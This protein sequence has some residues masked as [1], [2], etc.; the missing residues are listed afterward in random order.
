[1]EYSAWNQLSFAWPEECQSIVIKHG[2]FPQKSILDLKCRDSNAK[3]SETGAHS[4]RPCRGGGFRRREY[5][6]FKNWFFAYIR[7]DLTDF[8]ACGMIIA[9]PRD[10]TG[11]CR[12]YGRLVHSPREGGDKAWIR[13]I[14][15]G[16]WSTSSYGSSC[17]PLQYTLL[18]KRV[19]RPAATGRSM[20]FEIWQPKE[21]TA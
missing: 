2:Y 14:S 3:K 12:K 15:G 18:Q 5:L 4:V 8:V 11:R 10:G 17:L 21:L 6:H 20:I 7:W 13:S 19:D 16:S 9:S 1:M